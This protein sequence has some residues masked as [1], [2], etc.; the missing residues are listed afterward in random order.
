MG[1]R[2]SPANVQRVLDTILRPEREFTRAYIDDILIFSNSF[3]EELKLFQIFF[4]KLLKHNIHLSPKKC[5]LSYPSVALLGQRVDALGL[6]SAK[7]KLQAITKLAFPRTLKQL[8]Y[9]LGLTSWLRQFVDH[10]AKRAA[11]LQARIMKLYQ[12]LRAKDISTVP[13]RAKE[14]T[15]LALDNSTKDEIESVESLQEAFK[16]VTMLIHFN[17]D[18]KLYLDLDSSGMSIGAMIYHSEKDPPT[19]K[20]VL[21]IMFLSRLLKP[22]ETMYWP[23]ELEIAGLCW[24]I[25]K[26]RHLI[27]SSKY[28]TIIYTDHQSLIQ[29]ATQTSRTTTSLV[30]LN[31]RHL[32]SS[33]Y[34]SRFRLEVRYRPGKLNVVPDAFPR[35]NVINSKDEDQN[36]PTKPP[37]EETEVLA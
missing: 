10:C 22:T 18:R 29:I 28:A 3:S 34:L 33:E 27:E 31:P 24:V 19:Q 5:F 17:P 35:L 21:P 26:I 25:A 20:S 7:D 32:R 9:Y 4:T 37:V 36:F 16:N 15:H 12:N 8:V 11:A 23:T 14:A 30:R 13:K 2:N 6:S 1:F